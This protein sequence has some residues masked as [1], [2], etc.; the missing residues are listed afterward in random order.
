MIDWTTMV[1][2]RLATTIG[3]DVPEG[4]GLWPRAWEIVDAPSRALMD[5][6]SSLERGEGDRELVVQAGVAVRAA[7]QLAAR[8]WEARR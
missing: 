4:I 7:W 3:E 6:M 1:A 2:R 8:E 5:E